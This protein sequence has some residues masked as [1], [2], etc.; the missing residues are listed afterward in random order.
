[1]YVSVYPLI[2]WLKIIRILNT[3]LY[4]FFFHFYT[5]KNLNVEQP[6]WLLSQ[7]AGLKEKIRERERERENTNQGD[8]NGLKIFQQDKNCKC[9]WGPGSLQFASLVKYLTR[10]K[11]STFSTTFLWSSKFQDWLSNLT[12]R[13]CLFFHIGNWIFMAKYYPR[14]L[15][16]F[17]IKKKNLKNGNHYLISI[18]NS[19]STQ[20]YQY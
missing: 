14:C 2:K 13:S 19:D 16:R 9:K 3:C 5:H 17:I 8:C 20:K 7:F 18:C 1:M 10:W 12:S 15:Q 4:I 11:Y 6:V